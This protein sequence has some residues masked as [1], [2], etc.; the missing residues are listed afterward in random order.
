MRRSLQ[1]PIEQRNQ[2][3]PVALGGS[4]VV[5]RCIAKHP[6]VLGRVGLDL[7]VD[8]GTGERILESC[9]RLVGERL[10]LDRARDVDA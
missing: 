2:G 10:I 6:A 1:L 8:A 5:D 3:L 4:G 9:L 7:V